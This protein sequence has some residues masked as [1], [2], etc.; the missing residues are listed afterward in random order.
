MTKV[1]WRVGSAFSSV[2]L[3]VQAPSFRPDVHV[4][5]SRQPAAFPDPSERGPEV[6]HAGSAFDLFIYFFLVRSLDRSYFG[7]CSPESTFAHSHWAALREGVTL[8]APPPSSSSSSSLLPII[9]SSVYDQPTVR[10]YITW[11]CAEVPLVISPVVGDEAAKVQEEKK[12]STNLGVAPQKPL[13]PDTTPP[14]LP[15]HPS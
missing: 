14:P 5:P 10:P 1:L 8:Q 13:P 15:H 6:G 4:V 3:R 12:K 11:R 2:S 7:C 9:T